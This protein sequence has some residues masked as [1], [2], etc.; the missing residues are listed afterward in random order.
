[1]SSNA[2]GLRCSI[3]DQRRL[4][5]RQS[6][7]TSSYAESPCRSQPQIWVLQIA[8]T[9][10]TTPIRSLPLGSIPFGSLETQI[11]AL[12]RPK[13]ASINI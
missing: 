3:I 5:S 4:S 7:G 6:C 1:M 8:A 9:E 11:E 13:E 10:N 2:T 12:K